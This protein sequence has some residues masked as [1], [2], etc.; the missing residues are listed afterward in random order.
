ML[1]ITELPDV[2]ASRKNDGNSEI[3]RFGISGSSGSGKKPE[4]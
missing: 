1:K 2:L 4:Y 3:V